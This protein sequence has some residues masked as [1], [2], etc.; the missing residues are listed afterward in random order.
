[1]HN[2]NGAVDSFGTYLNRQQ[3]W[4]TLRASL[5]GEGRRLVP[6]S[7][8]HTYSLRGQRLGMDPG[9]VIHTIVN[10]LEVHLRSH[11]ASWRRLGC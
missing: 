2:G 5:A 4:Q 8:R 1:M 11:P 9:T 10:S 6:Y 3:G 7:F